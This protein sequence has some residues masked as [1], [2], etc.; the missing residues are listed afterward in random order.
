MEEFRN[1]LQK[2]IKIYWLLVIVSAVAIVGMYG[3]AA[4]T[5]DG[6][7]GSGYNSGFFAAMLVV[8]L[9]HIKRNKMALQDENLFKH[10]Y[11]RNTDERNN[12]IMREASKTSFIITIAGMSLATMVISYFS[13]VVSCTLSCC[14]AFIL[15]VYFGVTAY[16][17][18]KM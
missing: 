1:K 4:V 15:I 14:M 3:F 16:Y 10:L 12:Q 5:G 18:R 7:Y 2:N 9:L 8:S 6:E 13:E 17:N 11:V